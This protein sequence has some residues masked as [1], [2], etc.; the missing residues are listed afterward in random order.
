MIIT[1]W[2]ADAR[3]VGCRPERIEVADAA[4]AS[5]AEYSSAGRAGLLGARVRLASAPPSGSPPQ[6]SG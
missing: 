3:I 1:G 4:L 5:F 2:T 6:I